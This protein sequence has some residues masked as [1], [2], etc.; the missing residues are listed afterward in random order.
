ML[1]FHSSITLLQCH[2]CSAG[3]LPIFVQCTMASIKYHLI[4]FI[5]YT[6][7]VCTLRGLRE[8]CYILCIWDSEKICNRNT[9]IFIHQK[10]WTKIS[11]KHNSSHS[12]VI[13]TFQFAIL[14]LRRKKKNSFLNWSI[15]S[16][17]YKCGKKVSIKNVEFYAFSMIA[18]KCVCLLWTY[19]I[20]FTWKY[21]IFSLLRNSFHNLFNFRF[22]SS[23]IQSL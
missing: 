18:I 13:L 5:E 4:S 14:L 8:H 11:T 21:W 10:E 1:R 19:V 3:K 2:C 17:F 12:S 6:L 23:S 7:R 20:T 9:K 15:F 16:F 22:E